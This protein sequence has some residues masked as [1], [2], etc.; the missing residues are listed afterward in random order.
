MAILKPVG[1]VTTYGQPQTEGKWGNRLSASIDSYQA[2]LYGVLEAATGSDWARAQREDNELLARGAREGARRA[3]AIQSWDDVNGVGDFFDYAGGLAVDSAPYI[4]EAVAGGLVTRGLSTGLR[5]SARAAEAAGQADVAYGIGKQLA[6]RSAIGGAVASYPSSV[7][8]ILQNQREAGDT[9][10]LSSALIGGVPYAAL[11]MFGLEGAASRGGL[12]RGIKYLDDA[13]WYKRGLGNAAINATAEG[14]SETGQEVINQGFGRMAV[15]PNATLTDADAL[16]RYKESFIGGAILGGMTGGFRRSENWHDEQF[17]QQWDARLKADTPADPGPQDILGG[18]GAA[19]EPLRLGYDPQ[20]NEPLLTLPSGE[21]VR[22]SEFDSLPPLAQQY[23]LRKQAIPTDADGSVAAF[24]HNLEGA[25]PVVAGEQPPTLAALYGDA[26]TNWLPD[27]DQRVRQLPGGRDL[28]SA[29]PDGFGGG[30]FLEPGARPAIAD[31]YGAVAITPQDALALYGETHGDPGL[32]EARRRYEESLREKEAERQQVEAEAARHRA[33]R[34]DALAT[35]EVTPETVKFVKRDHIKALAEIRGLVQSGALAEKDGLAVIGELKFNLQAGDNTGFKQTLKEARERAAQQPVV[36]GNA[37]VAAGAPAGRSDQRTGGVGAARPVADEAGLNAPVVTPAVDTRPGVDPVVA[38]VEG[39]GAERTGELTDAPTPS[40]RKPIGS[41]VSQEELAVAQPRQIVRDWGGGDVEVVRA[42]APKGTET[43][44]QAEFRKTYAARMAAMPADDRDLL[45]RWTGVSVSDDGEL[46]FGKEPEAY[47]DIA[48]TLYNTKTKKL[49]VSAEIVRERVKAALIRAGADANVSPKL[50]WERLGFDVEGLDAETV[51]RLVETVTTDTQADDD[52]GLDPASLDFAGD[53]P[54]TDD[55]DTTADAVTSPESPAGETGLE[56]AVDLNRSATDLESLLEDDLRSG[57]IKQSDIEEVSIFYGTHRPPHAPRW[58]QLS[59]LDQVK[60]VNQYLAAV[61]RMEVGRATDEEVAA[62]VKTKEA[63]NG[64]QNRSGLDKRTDGRAVGGV[65]SGAAGDGRQTGPVRSDARHNAGEQQVPADGGAEQVVIGDGAAA[66]GVKV[67]RAK[68]LPKPLPEADA[69]PNPTPR[70][71]GKLGVKKPVQQ[72]AASETAPKWASDHATE[73]GGAVVFSQGDVALVRGFS[74]LTGRHVYVG[75][76]ATG[77]RTRT[78]IRS[79][80]GRVF[81][82]EQLSLLREQAESAEQRD[83]NDHELNPDG[84]FAEGAAVAASES[85]PAKA[86]DYLASLL[87]TLNLDGVR[88]FLTAT[89]DMRAAGA[90]EKYKLFGPMS[91]AMSAGLDANEDGSFRKFGDTPGD[92]YISIRTGLADERLVETIAHEVGHL[93]ERVALKKASPAVQAEIRDAYAQWLQ[94]VKGMSAKDLAHALRNAATAEAHAATMDGPASS[95]SAYWTSFGEWFADNTSR[96]ATSSAK[97][98]TLLERFFAGLVETY[99]KIAASLTGRKYAPNA[100]VAKFLDG[101][102]ASGTTLDV[103]DLSTEP[104]SSKSEAPGRTLKSA[105]AQAAN[106]G[107]RNAWTNI[108]DAF[109]K[110][111]PVALTNT[112]LAEQFGGKLPAL[113]SRAKLVH[114][115]TQTRAAL[116]Q[117][118]TDVLVKWDNLPKDVR[119]RLHQVMQDATMMEAHPDKEFGDAANA[120]LKPEM[121]AKHDELRSRYKALGP[122]AHKVYADGQKVLADQWKARQHGYYTLVDNIVAARLEAA[123]KAG[124]SEERLAE[125]EADRSRL[126]RRYDDAFAKIKGPYWPLIRFGE[127][128]AVGESE[129]YTE[130]RDRWEAAT[131]EER[132]KLKAELMALRKDAK[133]YKVIA[134]ENRA[135]L[136]KAK[137]EM[138]ASGLG[139]REDMADIQM[140]SMSRDS[141]DTFMKYRDALIDEMGSGADV[142]PAIRAMSEVFLQSLPEIHAL[143]RE[144]QRVGVAGASLDMQ[145]A[146]ATTVNQ[147]A[148]YASRLKYASALQTNAKELRKDGKGNVDLMHIVREMQKRQAL[149][150]RYTQTP[151]QDMASSLS[152]LYYLGVSPAFLIMNSFQTALVAAPVL[153]GEFGA[154]KAFSAVKASYLDALK[155]LKA[156]RYKN[157]KWDFWGGIDENILKDSGERLAL[158]KLLQ[159]G[160]IDEGQQHEINMFANDSSRLMARMSRGMGW[161]TQQIELVNRIS[162]ALAAYR[163]SHERGGLNAERKPKTFDDHVDFAYNQTLKTQMDYSAENT[164]RLMRQGGPVPLAKLVFQFRRYQQGML[165]LLGDNL[166]K[167]K[168][169]EH[170]TALATLLYLTAGAGMSAGAMGLPFMGAL[171]WALD[172]GLDDDDERGDAQTRMRNALFDLT[173]DKHTADALAKGLPALFGVDISKRIGLGDIASPF[174]MAKFDGRTGKDDVKEL[175]FSAAGPSAGLLAQFKDGYD[176]LA[177]GDVAKGME[178]LVPKFAADIFKATRYFNE[179]MTDSKGEPVPVD[180]NP[181]LRALGV[182]GTAESRYYEGTNAIREVQR[183]GNERLGLIEREFKSAVRSGDFTKARE[184]IAE[185]NADHPSRRIKPKQELDWR[186]EIREGAKDRAGSGV[187]FDAK[188]DAPYKDTARFATAQ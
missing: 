178:K 37:G 30:N 183:A 51:N 82:P 71:S 121:K 70:K 127:Y 23:L 153:A 164:A 8:D 91:S 12:A 112:Q 34:Q 131:G 97:P 158:R 4:A 5:A 53:T 18:G 143:H 139:V 123:I 14:L 147:G 115:M 145:R 57:A 54:L 93:V 88:V 186:R 64:R 185:W 175:L 152:W 52:A 128:L 31:R 151:V 122:A 130:L 17:K 25:V 2:G 50:L 89:E 102:A 134:A 79:F 137:K 99:R 133:H 43:P 111:S 86:R 90:K 66:Q 69:A 144:A 20:Y 114:E 48:P 149:D 15:D 16:N 10:D 47:R 62:I 74:V 167:L 87:K 142:E 104:Q 29:L 184:M 95:L 176:R 40:W 179:G 38:G 49:G 154:G 106:E 162:T 150:M 103:S 157:G 138:A 84:P 65:Q 60:V 117:A 19:A 182:S 55:G 165:Y 27:P 132:N 136:D 124:E 13:A 94:E 46:T 116:A 107:A 108:R 100:A 45:E 42:A 129:Q 98:Q 36:P 72:R 110:Y 181:V 173:G 63:V 135:D 109:K 96:W 174:P 68:P 33:E 73:V 61:K 76:H 188:R 120:H 92:F 39:L 177:D 156:A 59:G 168:G 155:L 80:T 141:H 105:A 83:A 58:D 101:M 161:A 125:I 119:V 148:F 32:I 85:V 159:L 172:K 44:E 24:A 170:K 35:F 21:A 56:T 146:F 160:I 169:E 1:P 22:K 9:T 26:D 6:R 78:D 171:L 140:D 3:G 118:G 113:R 163:L 7:G 28:D 81:S 180:V 166:K 126:V 77:G 11:N 75:V 67:E 187:R 41:E